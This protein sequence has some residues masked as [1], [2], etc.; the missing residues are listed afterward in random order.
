MNAQNSQPFLTLFFIVLRA[1]VV[2][3]ITTSIIAML[4]LAV[5]YAL[6]FIIACALAFLINP[7]VL[8]IEKKRGCPGEQPHLLFSSLFFHFNR[9]SFIYCLCSG[10][11]RCLTL[12][13]SA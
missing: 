13:D 5:R 4:M 12:P 3:A 6:P 9:Q 10:S 7:L 2:I 11:R 8:F 1:L